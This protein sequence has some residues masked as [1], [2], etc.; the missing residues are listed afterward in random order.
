MKVGNRE[1]WKE[2]EKEMTKGIKN[3]MKTAMTP[4]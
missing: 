2:E 1:Y 3:V 4:Q